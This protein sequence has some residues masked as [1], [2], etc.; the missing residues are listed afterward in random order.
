MRGR[1]DI[2]LAPG[3]HFDYGWAASPGECL[4]YLT[5]VIRTAIE[6]MERHPAL[7]FTIEYVLF[8]KHFLEV[9]P[10]YLTTVK[11]LLK[12]GRLEVGSIMSGAIEQWLDGEMLIH[13]LVRAKRW[14][15]KTLDYDPVTAQHTDLPGH[16]IQIAQFLQNAEIRHLAYS[17]W[18]PPIPLH[19]WR[20]PDGSEVLACCHF[21][22]P[23]DVPADWSGYGW[24][25][26]LFVQNTEME[27]VF[28]QLPKDLARRDTF[29]PA[30]QPLLMG[31]QSDLQPIEPEMLDRVRQWNARYPDCRI[32]V[33][34]ISQFF[35]NVDAD[36][37]PVYQGE[38]PYSFYAL[39]S[40]YVPCAREMRRGENAIAAGE[41]WSVFAE[42]AGLGRV[43]RERIGRARDALFLP[44]DHNTAGRRG[45]V[46]DAERF[47][48]ALNARLEG[49]SILQENAMRFTVNI[50]YRS[51][52]DGAYPITVFNSLSWDRD[53]IVE[54]YIEVPMNR[55]RGLNMF[56]SSGKPV[57]SQILSTDE[58]AG[59]SRVTFVFLARNVP[60]HGYETFYVR[61]SQE[62]ETVAALKVSATRM[63]SRFFDIRVGK[64]RITSIRWN[65]TQLVRKPARPFNAIYALEDRMTNIE[66]APWEVKRNYTGKGWDSTVAK[67]EVI[68]RGPVRAVLRFHG[69]IL[70]TRFFQDVIL[71]DDLE[72]IDLRHTLD[73]RMKMHTQT[74]VAFPLNIR[75]GEATYESP[76]GAVR[77]E[78]DEM[79]DTFRG[80]GERWV[81]KWI[82]ISNRQFGVTVATRQVS[83]VIRDDSVD[84]I[85]LRTAIDC[86]TPFYYFDQNG[87]HVFEHAICPHGGHR[88]KAAA[89][90]RGWEFN[91]PLYACNWT[92]CFPIK[93]LRLNR[94]LPERDS[95]F[96]VNR[97]NVVVAA[98]APSQ[99]DPNAVIVR[100]VE[101]H[102]RSNTVTLSCKYPCAGAEETN[103]LERRQQML[104]VD[105]N[106]VF[107]KVKP[108]GIHTV[109]LCA[110]ASSG[111]QYQ[112]P[113]MSEDRI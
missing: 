26:S 83:H 92:P 16:V 79:P 33:S 75:D 106:K 51:L 76:Y 50:A 6:D 94:G 10:E 18:H 37:I 107:L 30:A 46:N 97:D 70:G 93:P 19:R 15:R 87:R 104:R 111:T 11:R 80:T 68:E 48:D 57:P 110:P 74:R 5:E 60:A 72:R 59:H 73:Y 55:L 61:P 54:T 45:E 29:W 23:Y 36:A 103:F 63:R 39:P 112:I 113:F 69:K 81:Q 71:Y 4:S 52:I 32:C 78:K 35:E 88:R 27:R 53:D 64:G 96:R 91:S 25:W 22:E 28:D 99:D 8:V 90:R 44:H 31:C 49:E 98:V 12:E 105:D 7:K 66:A 42:L 3:S 102:G 101:F 41:K 62:P 40:C 58:A 109:R 89:H 17:R 21:H 82:D 84:P 24:G 77:L 43:Q 9:Y 56:N 65:G 34:T 14:V 67:V 95:F 100:I 13:Q 108:Y 2:H 85:L 47:K 20:S 38:S 1:W 86:G